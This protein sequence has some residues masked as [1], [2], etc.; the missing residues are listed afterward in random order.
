VKEK[1]H[2]LNSGWEV[3]VL[4]LLVL[5]ALSSHRW[6]TTSPNKSFV[7]QVSNLKQP[8]TEEEIRKAENPREKAF[9]LFR[10]LYQKNPELTVELGRIPEFADN[11]V[12][13]EDLESLRNFVNGYLKYRNSAVDENIKE[14][15]DT[16]GKKKYRRFCTPIQA[17]F[18][19]AEKEEII[20]EN[21][22][23]EI[24]VYN[25]LIKSWRKS[26]YKGKKWDSFNE[27]VDRLNDPY[28]LSRYMLDN[29]NF[30]YHPGEIPYS[31]QYFFKTQ[32]GDC[33]DYAKFATFCLTR[34]GYKAKTIVIPLTP[35]ESHV[36]SVYT[37][38]NE[39]FAIDN[40]KI[41][42]PFS[43]YSKMIRVI[44]SFHRS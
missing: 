17:I 34:A 13:Q 35:H 21:N 14:M 40:G 37:E 33:K 1:L 19:I 39:F 15:I 18:W 16:V 26:G 25:L 27:V 12:S 4:A 2:R 23:F 20:K 31:P 28:L 41:R 11:K 7:T 43:S 8:P 6:A 36:I 24:N 22:P 29:F 10:Q 38:D 3:V 32:K 30:V 5:V 42:G 9:I 44:R